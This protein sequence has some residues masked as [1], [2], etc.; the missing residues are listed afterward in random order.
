MDQTNWVSSRVSW[1]KNLY[2]LK[3]IKMTKWRLHSVRHRTSI[4]P[5]HVLH[6][7]LFQ[8]ALSSLHWTRASMMTEQAETEIEMWITS[9]ILL[10][11]YHR[12]LAQIR[13]HLLKR[14]LA[15]NTLLIENKLEQTNWVSSRASWTKNLYNLK[16]SKMTSWIW[17]FS[18]H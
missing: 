3:K 5:S 8:L 17:R 14:N 9:Y 13:M 10:R 1:T 7:V 11:T 6:I 15:H 16:K 12:H 2:N 4:P 18:N